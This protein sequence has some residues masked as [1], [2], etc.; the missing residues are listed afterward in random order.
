[1]NSETLTLQLKQVDAM[2]RSCCKSE[3]QRR[4]GEEPDRHLST[5]FMRRALVYEVQAQA[6]GGLTARARR[7]L[8]LSGQQKDTLPQS[9]TGITVGTQLL[10]E[11]NG[12]TYQVLVTDK[13]FELDGRPYR[14]LSAIAR[15]ITGAH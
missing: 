7:A 12:R 15:Q 11:W 6:L 14:S 3:W 2:D 1:M 4:F 5:R 10:H 9:K 8:G 13:G